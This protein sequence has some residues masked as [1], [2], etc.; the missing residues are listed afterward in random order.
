MES[1]LVASDSENE[2]TTWW[3]HEK[4][5]VYNLKHT[6]NGWSNKSSSSSVAFNY[7]SRI[8]LN[9]VAMCSCLRIKE[10]GEG[11]HRQRELIGERSNPNQPVNGTYLSDAVTGNE[12]VRRLEDVAAVAVEGWK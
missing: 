9:F 4:S 1:E 3:Q 11:G 5:S 8:A 7:S 6:Q 12:D 10:W 2:K